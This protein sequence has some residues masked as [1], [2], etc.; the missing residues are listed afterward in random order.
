VRWRPA[1]LALHRDVGFFAIGLTVVYSVSGIAVNHREDWNY[2]TATSEET[3]PLGL[4]SALLGTPPGPGGL[5]SGPSGLVSLA[6]AG[7]SRKTASGLLYGERQMLC[8]SF[9]PLV[10]PKKAAPRASKQKNA[11]ALFRE[12]R[13]R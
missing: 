6:E 11:L 13:M 3:R 5:A 9:L 8:T 10:A 1:L 4:P 12:S 7:W 2:N